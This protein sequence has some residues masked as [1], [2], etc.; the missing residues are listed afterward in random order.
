VSGH[1]C[2]YRD[3]RHAL[4]ARLDAL[5]REL[6]E[7]QAWGAARDG[8]CGKLRAQIDAL[9]AR[10]E[11][12][13][14]A[15]AELAREHGAPAAPPPAA[16]APAVAPP[17]APPVAPRARGE[18][19]AA[20]VV[21]FAAL[22]AGSALGA[23][24]RLPSVL[25]TSVRSAGARSAP[26]ADGPTPAERLP[27][28]P[29]AVDASALLPLARRLARGNGAEFASFRARGVRPDGTLDVGAQGAPPPAT[30]LFV[31]P[32]D[33]T[34]DQPPG[35]ARPAPPAA[36]A[37]AIDVT[38][39]GMQRPRPVPMPDDIT[40]NPVREPRCSLR[41]LWGAA[42]AAGAPA[43]AVATVAYEASRAPGPRGDR[44]FVGWHFAVEGTPFA[45]RMSDEE[46]LQGYVPLTDG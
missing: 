40:G 26:P 31:R 5:T 2:G 10:L 46:C 38:R 33:P 20:I 39:G 14:R 3:G 7:A 16:T 18:R 24:T 34:A 15:F 32:L 13:R 12:E 43:G 28:G 23:G 19:R 6:A 29:G 21:G 4:L 9:L 37:Y 45:F 42:R 35:T 36:G 41:Q 30:L 27:G 8:E 25:V 1:A 11:G 22:V 44:V 17:A